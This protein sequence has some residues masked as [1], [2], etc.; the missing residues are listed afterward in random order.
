MGQVP[1]NRLIPTELIMCAFFLLKI[2]I[3][4]SQVAFICTWKY[5]KLIK[6]T[7][8]RDFSGAQF[9]SDS[10]QVNL[11]DDTLSPSNS[12]LN[13]ELQICNLLRLLIQTAFCNR[14]FAQLK[15]FSI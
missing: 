1:L 6:G 4:R 11:D 2:K 13:Y 7:P 5:F 15:R 3:C 10:N 9:H 14:S 8:A 12:T